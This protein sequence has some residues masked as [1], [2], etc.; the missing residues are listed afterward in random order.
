M[1]AIYPESR[2]E[3]SVLNNEM[4]AV[5]SIWD[6][7]KGNSAQVLFGIHLQHEPQSIYYL[8]GKL[9]KQSYIKSAKNKV[10]GKSFS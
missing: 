4:I 5:I 10:Y 6:F 2:R 3:I 7:Q 9:S 8:C 1:E